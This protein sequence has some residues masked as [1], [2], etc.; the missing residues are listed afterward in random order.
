MVQARFLAVPGIFALLA[1]VTLAYAL[2][3]PAD[4]FYSPFFWTGFAFFFFVAWFLIM[5]TKIKGGAKIGGVVLLY[6]MATGVSLSDK[7]PDA[8]IFVSGFLGLFVGMFLKGAIVISAQTR[9]RYCPEC[10]KKNWFSQT[11]HGWVCPKGH[12]MPTTESGVAAESGSVIGDV[13]KQP[14]V[15]SANGEDLRAVTFVWAKV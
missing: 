9:W 13:D 11:D 7:Y 10:G 14:T 3:T 4:W 5:N 8:F 12:A 1:L 2:K 15:S 6:A